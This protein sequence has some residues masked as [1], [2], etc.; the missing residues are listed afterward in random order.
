MYELDYCSLL[1]LLCEK[2]LTSFAKH[3][4]RYEYDVFKEQTR[5]NSFIPAEYFGDYMQTR[6][7]RPFVLTV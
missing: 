7:C 6:A 3:N 2:K 4:I 1:L 5:S